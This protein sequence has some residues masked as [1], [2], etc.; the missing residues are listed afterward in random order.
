MGQSQTPHIPYCSCSANEAVFL[1]PRNNIAHVKPSLS[2][3]QV[4]KENL[5]CLIMLLYAIAWS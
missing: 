5:S 1:S 2:A 3:P 4:C